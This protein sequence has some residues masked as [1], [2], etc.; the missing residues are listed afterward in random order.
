MCYLLTYEH[1]ND[2]G[3]QLEE[4]KA[5]A[6]AQKRANSLVNVSAIS[7]IRLWK[8]EARPIVKQHVEWEGGE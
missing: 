4:F 8:F 2:M 7:N 1:E 6:D 5:K 3:A